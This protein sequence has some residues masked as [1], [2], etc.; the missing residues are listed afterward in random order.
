MENMEVRHE[1]SNWTQFIFVAQ[2]VEQRTFKTGV[3]PAEVGYIF[4]ALYGFPF[5]YY[6]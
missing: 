6:S 2:S 4:F 1:I 3:L 5:P